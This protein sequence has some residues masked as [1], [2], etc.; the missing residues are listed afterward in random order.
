MPNAV[1]SIHHLRGAAGTVASMFDNR[2]KER[3]LNHR[4]TLEGLSTGDPIYVMGTVASRPREEIEA[5][6]IDATLQNA[7]LKVT[8]EKAPGFKPRLERGTE[9][10]A[11]GELVGWWIR[12]SGRSSCCSGPSLWR[13][14]PRMKAQ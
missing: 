12:S 4:W 6:G 10:S 5:E 13:S 8:G 3:I 7:L 11:L 14:P 2:R 9:L 1:R